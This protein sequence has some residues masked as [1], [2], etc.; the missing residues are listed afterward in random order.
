[1][2]VR[3][4]K[5]ETEMKNGKLEI[6]RKKEKTSYEYPAGF[7]G[8]V[9]NPGNRRMEKMENGKCRKER[10]IEGRQIRIRREKGQKRFLTP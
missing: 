9:D 3:S 10:K 8:G 1:M 2:G 5:S 6:V 7:T 4:Q